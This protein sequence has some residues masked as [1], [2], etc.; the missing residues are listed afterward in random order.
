MII[1]GIQLLIMELPTELIA[2]IAAA[3]GAAGRLFCVFQPHTYSRTAALMDAFSD[4]LR[5]CDE[6][7]VMATY[8]AREKENPHAS[9][10][11]LSKAC[12]GGYIEDAK[13]GGRW[14][15]ERVRAG[16]TVLLAGAGDVFR[17]WDFFKD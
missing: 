4:A 12:G 5:L 1:F 6:C 11:A 9:G 10:K 16:D 17:V 8:A 13:A 3:R 14:L 7:A 2:A 15:K